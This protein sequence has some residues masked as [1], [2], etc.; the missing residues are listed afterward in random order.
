MKRLLCSLAMVLCLSDQGSAAVTFTFD[1]DTQGFQSVNWNPGNG[2]VSWSPL[3]GGS[4]L[5]TFTTSGWSNPLGIIEMN[6]NPALQ[7]EFANL[8][9]NGGTLTFDM[10]IRQEDV[11]GYNPAT[12][13]GWF[14]MVVTG[15]SDA[16]AGGGWDP[17]SMG[18]ADGFAG[19]IPS[20]YTTKTISLSVAAGAPVDNNGIVTFGAT[21]SWNQL[22]FGI[23][24][25]GGSFTSALVYLD[26]ITFSATTNT[27]GVSL[28]F[29][30][31]TD[32]FQSVGWNLANG[33][34][35]WSPLHGGS[36]LMTFNSSGWS[37]PLG[38]L[39]MN[40]SPALF[41]EYQNILINGGTMTFD[42]II[43]QE[44]VSGYDTNNPPGW[45]ELFVIGNSSAG[46]DQN[47]VGGDAGFY[48]GIPAGYTT[49]SITLSMAAGPPVSNDNIVS[50]GVGSSWNELLI[51]I[52]SPSGAFT[53]ALVYLDNVTFAANTTTGAD[54][55]GALVQHFGFEGLGSQVDNVKSLHQE[56]DT[57]T[58]LTYN[59]LINSAQG[60]NGVVFDINDLG[61]GD[62]LSA[63][64]FEFQMSPTGAFSEAGNPPSNWAA[65]PAPIGITVT[66]GQPDRVTIE[67]ADN[68]IVDRWLRITILAN[69]NTGLAAPEV[70][71]LGHLRGETTGPDAS[72]Y[73][74][75]FSD[76]TPI[77]SQVGS[78][79]DSGS[80][81]D[82]D[83]NGVVAF[84]D[85]TAMRGNVGAQLTNIT[86]PEA[87]E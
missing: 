64:D 28:P 34:V 53:G 46:W 18:G 60:I 51:G 67:W 44:D 50:F 52:N 65:A 14:E 6:S 21:S 41:A 61:N 66:P 5:M 36:L 48:G 20:G 70:Y 35:S 76:I 13:P 69:E 82:I 75:A 83:K 29:D 23:N 56:G 4:L 47:V 87:M 40:A 10:I 37:N 86:V 68:A 43:R 7:A 38:I 25:E 9:A 26:N 42:F 12:P 24:S 33:G 22:L 73:T 80:T 1:S 11:V 3:H 84:A 30:S 62:S 77:R 78:N 71:Y 19:G 58:L 81:L 63:S 74:I 2:G 8:L 16:G 72:I 45:F 57:P 49:K 31:T 54:V 79:A 39:N 15:N 32:G 85:I 27:G 17:N 55:V 59:N